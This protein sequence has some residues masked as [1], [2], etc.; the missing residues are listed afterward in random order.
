MSAVRSGFEPWAADRFGDLDLRACAETVRIDDY[1][2][3]LELALAAAPPGPWIYTGA[4]ENRPGL[5]DRLSASRRL[6]GI[7]GE[8][9]RGVRDPFRLAAVLSA[10]GLNAPRNSRSADCLPRDGSWLRKPFASAGGVGVQVLSAAEFSSLK[11]Q[12][13]FQ[14]P[15]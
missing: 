5:I 13:Y 8:S 14:Q 6:L 10:A 4:L 2:A 11:A 3:G 7:G 9:L 12:F 15:H 1:P